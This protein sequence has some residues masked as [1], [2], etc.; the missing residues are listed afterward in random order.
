MWTVI[1]YLLIVL[2][3]MVAISSLWSHLFEEDLVLKK[4]HFERGMVTLVVFLILLLYGFFR[5]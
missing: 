4:A 5:S 2:C 3:G 1:V